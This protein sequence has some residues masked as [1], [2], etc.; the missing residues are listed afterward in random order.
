MFV[1]LRLFPKCYVNL[2]NSYYVI[3]KNIL[4]HP[5]ICLPMLFEKTQLAKF[6]VAI[7]QALS[8]NQYRHWKCLCLFILALTKVQLTILQCLWNLLFV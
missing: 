4:G 3:L 7:I 6:I 2:Q 8:C 1:S 5:N